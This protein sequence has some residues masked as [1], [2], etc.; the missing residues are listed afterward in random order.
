MNLKEDMIK[1]SMMLSILEGFK[2]EEMP[3]ELRVLV[4]SAIKDYKEKRSTANIHVA[5]RKLVKFFGKD[6]Y[7]REK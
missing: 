5:Y 7:S 6:Y 2:D 1:T 3:D 4:N